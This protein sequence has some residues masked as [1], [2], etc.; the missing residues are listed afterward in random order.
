MIVSCHL[1]KSKKNKPEIEILSATKQTWIAGKFGS[2]AG[3][4]FEVQLKVMTKDFLPC[5]IKVNHHLLDMYMFKNDTPT[6]SYQIGDT[7]KLRAALNYLVVD[8]ILKE[9]KYPVELIYQVKGIDK[10]LYLKEI[11][12]AE[13]LFYP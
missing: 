5:K 3:D 7:L 8:S 9:I 10:S 1:Q 11:K 4:R 12:K 2:G 13:P 6:V